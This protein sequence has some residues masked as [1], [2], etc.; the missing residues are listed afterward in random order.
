MGRWV[1][2]GGLIA[3]VA[4]G[5]FASYSDSDIPGF[6][7]AS[8][9]QKDLMAKATQSLAA[10]KADWAQLKVSGQIAKLS[11]EARTEAER[12]LAL[13]VVRR[14]VWAGGTF[15]GGIV[16]V[17]DRTSLAPAQTPFTWTANITEGRHLRITGFAPS[18]AARGE[19]DQ[20][21]QKLFPSGVEDLSRVARGAPKG[22]WVAAVSW[23]LPALE[24]LGKH[25]TGVGCLYINKLKDI[26]LVTLQELVKRS[27]E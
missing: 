21:A 4:L 6:R 8:V 2:M 27:V 11:G 10:I 22:N 14:S 16:Y 15:W 12:D 1:V 9:I 17:R 5:L 24:K 23:M 25:K 26:D 20:L 7:S 18:E 3:L 19:V 13:D